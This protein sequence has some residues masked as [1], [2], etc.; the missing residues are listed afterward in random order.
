M[1]F[2]YPQRPVL[3]HA[4]QLIL[5]MLYCEHRQVEEAAVLVGLLKAPTYYSPVRNP[6]NST[7]RRN[8]VL[9][10][11]RKYEYL[12]QAEYDSIKTLPLT[13][14]YKTTDHNGNI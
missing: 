1:P 3:L 7:G 8:V 11:M 14:N 6:E 5:Q 12:K 10:Q 9:L 13:L 2:F 4:S